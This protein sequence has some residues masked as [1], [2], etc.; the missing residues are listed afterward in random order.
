MGPSLRRIRV[1]FWS[2]AVAAGALQAWGARF[3][4]E[5][6]G[7]NYLDIADAYLRRD[8]S[9]AIN[10]YWSPFYSWLLALVRWAFHPSPYW[11]STALHLLNFVLFLATILC[12]EFFYRRLLF[13]LTTRFPGAV[14]K[15]GMP[16][17]SWW[18][19]GYTAFL[20]CVLRSISL[21][22]DTPDL[23]LAGFFFL[24]CGMIVEIAQA[25]LSVG[26]HVLLGIILGL[27]YLTKSVMFPLSFVFIAAGTFARNGVKKPDL[28]GLLALPAF[29]LVSS[30]FLAALS[31]STGHLTFGET[32]KLAYSRFVNGFHWGQDIMGG[33]KLV[34]PIRKLFDEPV[35]YEFAAPIR[36]TYPPWYDAS[37]WWAG[38]RP[39]FDLR[40]QLRVLGHS[41][42]G[43]LHILSLEKE[44][45][46][47]LLVLLLF[48]QCWAEQLRSLRKLWFLW[49]PSLAT[50]AIYSL[51]L[52]EPRYVAASIAVL[53]VTLFAAIP[54]AR[55]NAARGLGVTVVLAIA[56]VSCVSLARE[57]A[58]DLAECLRPSEHVQWVVAKNLQKMGLASGDR[59]AVLG[60]T[61]IADYWARL[62]GLQIVADV[63]LEAVGSYGEATPE[64][65]SQISARLA[66]LG[67]K[68]MVSA[69]RPLVPSG[70]RPVGTTGYYVLY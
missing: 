1:S 66:A 63:P 18:V 22:N 68:A 20:I 64:K 62:A 39:H 33:G 10:A 59:V 5:P 61:T 21:R 51:V 17:W 30:P 67:V 46:V 69:E 47:G 25:G 58:P 34:H 2:I 9:A 29:L 27:A 32:G 54:W 19:L 49:L 53:W 35:V 15:E 24:A 60:H 38:S 23:A 37:Y 3:V 70:W 44:W 8:W 42:T 48:G 57:E 40:G 65:R 36:A 7:V 43:Y 56:I 50:L 28:R 41:A 12:F 16:Q 55:I 11:E 4:I 13:L 6:D 26:K 31:A 45:I 52:V 14:S